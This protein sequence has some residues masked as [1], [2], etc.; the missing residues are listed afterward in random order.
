MRSLVLI[1]QA[2]A[3]GRVCLGGDVKASAAL[4]AFAGAD[5]TGQ[6]QH[7]GRARLDGIIERS[8][9]MAEILDHGSIPVRGHGF[10]APPGASWLAIRTGHWKEPRWWVVVWLS[11]APR[12]AVFARN[13][14]PSASLP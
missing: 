1:E 3:P 5:E 7:L 6:G 12:S 2:E 8:R 9:D 10:S 14:V 4:P 11:P 13:L